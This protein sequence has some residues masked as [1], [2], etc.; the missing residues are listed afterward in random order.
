MINW[1]RLHP[2][3]FKKINSSEWRF[4]VC[5]S[6]Y[7]HVSVQFFPYDTHDYTYISKAITFMNLKQILNIVEPLF[8]SIQC[9]HIMFLF[10]YIWITTCGHIGDKNFICA[11]FCTRVRNSSLNLLNHLQSHEKLNVQSIGH[12]IWQ[13]Q[14]LIPDTSKESPSTHRVCGIKICCDQTSLWQ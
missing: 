7:F 6:V 14:I 3:V 10:M 11:H 1:S 5:V 12:R 2:N 9:M 13:H 8:F 4:S